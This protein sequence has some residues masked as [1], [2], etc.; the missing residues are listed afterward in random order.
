MD[1]SIRRV[2]VLYGGTSAERDV[3]LQSGEAVHAALVSRGHTA[4]LLDVG[5]TPVD[6]IA[7]TEFDCAYIALHGTYGE[8]GGVQRDLDALGVPYTGSDVRASALAFD[9]WKAKAAF[10][11]ADVATPPAVLIESGSR[12]S[13]SSQVGTAARRIGYP[14]AVKPNAQGS[15]VGVTIVPSE[16]RIR[17]A[18][19]QALRYDSRV[20]IERAIPGEEWTVG[21]IDR[22]PLPAIRIEAARLFYDYEAKYLAED[23]RYHTADASEQPEF[24]ARLQSTALRACESLSTSGIARVDIRV[25]ECGQPWV[26]EV[27]TIPGMTSHSLIPMAAA[28][29]GLSFAELCHRALPAVSTSRRRAG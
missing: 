6:A 24:V 4:E 14:M 8:D 26:L 9:K 20:L 23:T 12:H 19:D 15:S 7:W 29:A 17:A 2:A 1:G 16:I 11:A 3:S 5:R 27:N 10:M 28:A 22:C 13:L 21:L 25:D 18:V